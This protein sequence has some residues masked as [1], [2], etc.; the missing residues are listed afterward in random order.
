M[1]EPC[2]IGKGNSSRSKSKAEQCKEQYQHLLRRKRCEERTELHVPP[3]CKKCPNYCPEFRYRYCLFARCP[4][5][6][7]RKVF[8]ARPLPRDLFSDGEAVKQ[9]V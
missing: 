4:Y 6:K 5:E 1:Q 2:K 9:R 8:R 7:Y 3:S